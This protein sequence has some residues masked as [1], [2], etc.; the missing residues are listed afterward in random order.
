MIAL[1]LAD[2][3]SPQ[4]VPSS[5]EIGHEERYD[6]SDDGDSEIA[7]DLISMVEEVPVNR[8]VDDDRH[9]ADQQPDASV[10]DEVPKHAGRHS[11]EH[12]FG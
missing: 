7:V 2:L 3:S 10:N 5:D 12:V 6:Q 9:W 8:F 1:S 4:G 11:L